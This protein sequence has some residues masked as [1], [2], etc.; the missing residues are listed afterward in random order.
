M[1]SEFLTSGR[2]VKLHKIAD[3]AIKKEFNVRHLWKLRAEHLST[4]QEKGMLLK[5]K[6]LFMRRLVVLLV[7]LRGGNRGDKSTT[8][9][10]T[11]ED[12]EDDL[13]NV[14]NM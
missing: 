13:V 6:Q 10:E 7:A 8:T 5:R 4:L 11:S 3:K 2:A 9:S 1:R 12:S 14:L